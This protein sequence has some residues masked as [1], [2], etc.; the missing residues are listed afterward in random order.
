[1]ANIRVL[2]AG[3]SWISAGTHI[4]GFD[5]FF[6][7]DYAIGIATLK[8]ALTGSDVELNHLPGHLVPSEFPS[9]VEAISQYNVVVMSDIGA[10]S[11]LVHPDISSTAT[12]SRSLTSAL[13]HSGWTAA[14]RR[15]T[16]ARN[17][18]EFELE[19]RPS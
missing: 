6:T 14:M 3:E 13:I 18:N 1:M 8:Q 10:N 7:A 19:D 12:V 9:T 2:L 16:S 5:Q 4:K 17:C 11:L 15:L